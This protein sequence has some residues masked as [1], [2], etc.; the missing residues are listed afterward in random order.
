MEKY[1]FV[2]IWYDR[3]NKMY[4]IGC[5]WGS[6]N[7][8]YVCSS[9]RMRMAFKRRPEDFKRRILKRNIPKEELLTE[10]H[11]W[12]QLIPDR[13]LGKQYYNHSKHHFGHWSAASNSD[14]IKE[15]CGAK[16]KGKK[17][18]LT[19]EQKSERGRRISEAKV[20]RKEEKLAL[21]LPIRQ[22]EKQPRQ[23]N[24]PQSEETKLKKSI[25]M[26]KKFESGEWSSW[27]KG[28]TLSPRS[29]ETKQKQS[30][31]LKG[32]KRDD[33]QKERISNANKKAWSEGKFTNR[34]SNNMKDYI[35]V[36][37]KEDNKRTRIKKETFD[38]LLYS[39]GR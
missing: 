3:K 14:I 17:Q 6:E 37:R 9:D 31:A 8:G 30:L 15:K 28:K 23:P 4:Y 33:E 2:Y 13:E 34:R 24:G 11:K 38:E 21:G 20:K 36:T 16:N 22:P 29:E 26:K 5:H 7:D 35:W 27:S 25:T 1:G 18:N 10:E 19:P 32:K 12:L 39:K